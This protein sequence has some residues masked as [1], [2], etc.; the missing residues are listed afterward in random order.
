[1]ADYYETLGVQKSASMDEIKSSYR[2][3][4]MKYHPDRNK[5]PGAEAKFKEISEAYAVLSDEKKRGI[6]DQYGKEGVSQQ[7]TQEDIFKG[8]NF[9]GFEDIFGSFGRGGAFSEDDL[10]SFGDAFSSLFGGASS[11]RRGRA[12]GQDLRCDVRMSLEDAFKGIEKE[13]RLRRNVTCPKC[14]G[15]RAEPGSNSGTCPNCRGAGQVRKMK[16]AGFMQF[17]TMA[18]CNQCGGTGITVDKR[19]SQCNGAGA[20][21]KTETLSVKIPAGAYQ[22]LTLR[23]RGEG[24]SNG[25]STGDLYVVVSILPNRNF[26]VDGRDLLT[27]KKI[28]FATAAIGGKVVVPTI[29]EKDAELSIPAGTQTHTKFRLR[30]QGMPGV[31]GERRGDEIVLVI[32][33]TPTSLSARQKELYEELAGGKEASE[34]PKKKGKKKGFLKGMLGL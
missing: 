12:R 24:E 20:I 25:Y 21:D 14:H 16:S 5:E 33:E 3:L 22:G 6:Y 1:M 11:S 4:A 15:S 23:L 19:C 8:A 10:G 18:P 9:S 17:V 7:F 29:D 28:S 2:K 30:G 26:E 32:V 27:E 34:K 31:E 13:I